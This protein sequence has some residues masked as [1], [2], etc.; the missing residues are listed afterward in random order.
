MDEVH[1]HLIFHQPDRRRSRSKIIPRQNCRG[2][3][4]VLF[5]FY[6]K[7]RALRIIRRIGLYT[8]KYGNKRKAPVLPQG[9]KRGVLSSISFRSR[10]HMRKDTNK[11]PS[12]VPEV[13]PGTS[14][15]GQM[16]RFSPSKEE[17]SREARVESG[18]ARETRTKIADTVQLRGDR[19]GLERKQHSETL[20]VLSK[21]PL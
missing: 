10:K 6:S 5:F 13:F 1:Y 8:G 7:K 12:Q 15:Q 11:Y 19:Y 20:P 17:S 9:L 2:L 3:Y 21:E 4:D 18:K 14:N 16:R